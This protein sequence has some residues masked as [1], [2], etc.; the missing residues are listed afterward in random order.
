MA[1]LIYTDSYNYAA[2]K[3]RFEGKQVTQFADKNDSDNLHYFQPSCLLY[4]RWI[5]FESLWLP[6]VAEL[7]Y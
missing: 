5:L 4:K 2:N 1:R 7:R 6:V 3:E